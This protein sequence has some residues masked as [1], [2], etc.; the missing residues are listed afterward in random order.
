MR[1]ENEQESVNIED[2]R[3]DGPGIG[4]GGGGG[5]QL[6]G[7]RSGGSIIGLLVLMAIGYFLGINPGQLMGGGSGLPQ[8]TGDATEAGGGPVRESAGEAQETERMKRVLGSTE[9]VWTEI[10]AAENARYQP[11]T[12][13]L[14]RNATRTAC[15]VG[16]AA[17][18]PFYCPGD[19]KVYIDLGFFD[20][21]ATRFGAP[22]DFAQAYVLAHEVGH[23]IQMLVGTEAK[24]RRAQQS[25]GNANQL[26]VAM[27]LQADC[28]AGVWANRANATKQILEPG[29]LEEGLKAAFAVGDDTLQKQTQGYVVPDSFTHGSSEQRMRWFKQGFESG[30]ADSCNT[31]GN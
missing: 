10:F 7:G 4:M 25:G 6:G 31:F 12:L 27:E 11:P 19:R 16:Q 23:H 30:N 3:G 2:R 9:R 8:L 15:G 21:L 1:L 24:V 14:F 26:Q 13:V 17:A 28:Y 18:G 22:G 29:D 5:L 20:E